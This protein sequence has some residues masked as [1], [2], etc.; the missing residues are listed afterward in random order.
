MGIK[1]TLIGIAVGVISALFFSQV[2]FPEEFE[3]L[4]IIIPP[5]LGGAV[6]KSTI[7][8]AFAGFFSHFIPVSGLGSL[9]LSIG[10]TNEALP[11][12]MMLLPMIGVGLN[13][14][15]ILLGGFGVVLG[16]IGSGISNKIF[17]EEE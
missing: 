5:L 13:A 1:R 16:I 15:G 8:G 7:G 17:P 14:I 2:N 6:A 9:L 12:P 11:L 4:T 10:F 3:I